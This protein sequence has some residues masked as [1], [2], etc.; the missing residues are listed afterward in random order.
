MQ[1]EA[2]NHLSLV[3]ANGLKE[4]TVQTTF[5]G[6]KWKSENVGGIGHNSAAGT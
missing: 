5:F 2:L 1:V 6:S 3:I 4:I